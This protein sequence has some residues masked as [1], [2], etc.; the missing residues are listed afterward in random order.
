ML[1][2]LGLSGSPIKLGPPSPE[3]R[4][5]RGQ[6]HRSL[7]SSSSPR[8]GLQWHVAAGGSRACLTTFKLPVG[9][10]PSNPSSEPRIIFVTIEFSK[11]G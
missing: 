4:D 1:Q 8:K 2:T 10:P 11:E 9:P 6:R 7:T 3:G 5:R